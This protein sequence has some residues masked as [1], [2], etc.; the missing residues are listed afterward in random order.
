MYE[1]MSKGIYWVR[2]T[3]TPDLIEFINIDALTR[4][5]GFTVCAHSAVNGP[6]S[7]LVWLTQICTQRRPRLNEI[8]M[9]ECFLT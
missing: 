9:L 1:C 5:S 7:L 6:N 8:G 3:I 4:I 2:L